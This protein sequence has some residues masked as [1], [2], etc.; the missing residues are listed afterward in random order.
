MRT[1]SGTRASRRS[2]GSFEESRIVSGIVQNKDVV[3]GW[4]RRRIENL[5]VVLL[6]CGPENKDGESRM[7]VYVTAAA[8][9][10]KLLEHEEA[11]VKLFDEV[12]RA[13]PDV[14]VT[15]MGISDI[16][17]HD[18]QQGGRLC[19]RA[20]AEERLAEACARDEGR[21]VT[22]LRSGWRATLCT[23][24]GM[25]SGSLAMST[26]VRR[27]ARGNGLHCPSAWRCQ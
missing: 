24:G 18:L 11:Y 13:R 17:Q 2:W 27:G 6:V 19:A 25:R 7:D 23:R 20:P 10:G 3:H 12:V 21:V 5:R 22:L 15:E 4:M 14:V 8:L 16:A 26:S 9:L 1:R